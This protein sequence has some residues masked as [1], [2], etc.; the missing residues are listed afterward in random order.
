MFSTVGVRRPLRYREIVAAVTPDNADNSAPF[1]LHCFM[2]WD[3][4]SENFL[5]SIG[6]AGKSGIDSGQTAMDRIAQKFLALSI[7]KRA[8]RVYQLHELQIGK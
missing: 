8:I 4:R 1:T 5:V 3:R 7:R 6:T 2:Q